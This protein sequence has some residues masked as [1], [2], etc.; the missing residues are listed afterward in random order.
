M[1]TDTFTNI[2]SQIAKVE[3]PAQTLNAGQE[4]Y[5]TYAAKSAAGDVIALAPGSA[6]FEVVTGKDSIM[7]ANG[8]V[9]KGIAGGVAT[10]RASVDGVVS[11]RA[12]FTVIASVNIAL[13]G[14]PDDPQV[15]SFQQVLA[16]KKVQYTAFSSIPDP[17][18]LQ[19]YDVL[20]IMGDTQ[21]F[22][23]VVTVSDAGK[24]KDYLNTGRGVVL[25]S[26]APALLAGSNDLTAISSWFSGAKRL[27]NDYDRT[28]IART[29]PG[30]FALPQALPTAAVSG[31][32][33]VLT[34]FI[35]SKMPRWIL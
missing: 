13:V 32:A 10:V 20:M 19:A 8:E 2:P 16:G 1:I 6:F 24:V 31:L 17:G 23:G 7:T 9:G 27:G 25:L 34:T 30:K 28:F 26:N 35:T 5:L 3:V 12:Q 14:N 33:T 11:D 18:A 4:K 15:I 21:S 22:D 29:S